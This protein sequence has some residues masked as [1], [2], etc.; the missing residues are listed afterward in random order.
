VSFDGFPVTSRG[1]TLSRL[2]ISTEVMKEHG[3]DPGR[4]GFT[5]GLE[6]TS[7]DDRGMPPIRVGGV[8]LMTISFGSAE[9][10][11]S[12]EDAAAGAEKDHTPVPPDDDLEPLK[13]LP[14][15]GEV[16]E[17]KTSSGGVVTEFKDG[18][19]IVSEP[20][21]G[22]TF[23]PDGG[24]V[25]DWTVE[26]DK[27]YVNPDADGG[28]TIDP[29]A[30]EAWERTVLGASL[31]VEGWA[32]PTSDDGPSMSKG[33]LVMWVDSE[34]ALGAFVAFDEPRVTVAQPEVRGDLPSPM[35]AA[36]KGA[37]TGPKP[38]GDCPVE[39]RC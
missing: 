27:K 8:D 29:A 25:V 20:T 33:T 14:F 10:G 11:A 34:L 31:A 17:A 16:G 7:K 15:G 23:D 32:A 1:E 30:F 36:P 39:G 19:T 21:W 37:G 13:D 18:T 26:W 24:I 2:G 6:H 28:T 38:A 5:I 3:V 9:H 35:D 4:T 22:A 12:T